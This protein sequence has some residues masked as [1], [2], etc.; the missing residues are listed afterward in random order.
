MTSEN[1]NRKFDR[2][3][4]PGAILSTIVLSSMV[5]SVGMWAKATEKD[6]EACAKLA[7]DNKQRVIYLEKCTEVSKIQN[8]T[9]KDKVDNLINKVDATAARQEKALDILN[10]QNEKVLDMVIKIMQNGKTSP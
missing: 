3:K 5:I 2:W 7:E 10:K 6:I 1:R 4:L 8:N 9:I